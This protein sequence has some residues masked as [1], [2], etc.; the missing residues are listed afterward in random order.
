MA[1]LTKSKSRIGASMKIG[2][3][4]SS[5]SFLIRKEAEK[6]M[7]RFSCILPLQAYV[8]EQISLSHVSEYPA[9]DIGSS[10][11]RSRI[12]YRCPFYHILLTN[13]HNGI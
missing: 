7:F 9:A 13:L 5:Q 2:D 8:G 10:E 1:N 11:M 12:K 6:L 3:K 4:A